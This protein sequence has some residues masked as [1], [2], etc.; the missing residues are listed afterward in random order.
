MQFRIKSKQ[1][2]HLVRLPDTIRNRTGFIMKL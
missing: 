2:F 1:N